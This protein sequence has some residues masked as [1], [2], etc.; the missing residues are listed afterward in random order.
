MDIKELK[1]KYKDKTAYIVGKGPSIKRLLS[2]HF[3][4]GVVITLNESIIVV[5]NLHLKNDI[6]SMQKDADSVDH[7][8]GIRPKRASLIIHELESY[9]RF[10]D[11]SPRYSFNNV[12]D[13]NMPWDTFSA[14]SATEICLLMGCCNIVYVCHDSC[15][16]GNTACC[17]RDKDGSFYIENYY[18][19]Y[20]MQAE[21]L[22]EYLKIKKIKHE[23]ITP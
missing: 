11:Y 9:Y 4:E 12:S 20:L 8:F 15:T 18:P 13:F 14:I 23:W 10:K 2:T 1:D 3:G 21:I 5:E 19:Q 16:T 7:V 6:Y 17:Q 22:K